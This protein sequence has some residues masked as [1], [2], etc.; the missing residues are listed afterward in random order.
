MYDLGADRAGM[1]FLA[2]FETPGL[3]TAMTIFNGLLYVAD[4]DSGL[5]VVNYLAYDSH[6]VAPTISLAASFP[7]NPAQAEEGKLVR[8]T[9]NVS[10]DV[11][12]RNVEFFV[13]GIRIATDGNFPF[14]AR[15]VT[16]LLGSGNTSFTVKAKATDTGGNVK[17]TDE[18]TVNLVPDATPPKLKH[19]FP[20]AGAI[21]G[22]ADTLVGYFSEPLDSS[23][24]SAASFTLINAG[25]DLAFGTPDDVTISGGTFTW[26]AELN[27][28]FLNFAANLPAGLY[29][30]TVKAP[31]ADLAHNPMTEP[32]SWQF[33]IIGQ[34]DSDNDGVPDNVEAALGLDPNNA[35][36]NGNGVLDGD[37]DFDGDGLRNRWELLFGYDPRKKDS[38]ENG[39]ADN[40]EDGDFDGLTNLQEQAAGS[41]PF[42]ADS[43]KDGRDDASEVADGT[44]PMSANTG[45]T[46]ELSSRLVSVLNALPEQLPASLPVQRAC[47]RVRASLCFP[48][49]F[50]I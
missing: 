3:A 31:I 43:D 47:L 26:R 41:N 32:A 15:F 19:T 29:K 4:G 5:S 23:T 45:F 24:I 38:D 39:I 30:A 18:T 44:N 50:L 33:W 20:T 46:F 7:L 28:A 11:Q 27:A 9:A 13:N 17:W 34:Q 1:T 49:E 22:S 42:S 35:D 6:G 21:V 16:P 40:L 10:D 25:A 48:A 36:T 14:E 2:T 8:I 37:E 12:V